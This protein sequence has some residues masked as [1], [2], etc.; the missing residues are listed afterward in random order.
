MRK[1]WKPIYLLPLALVALSVSLGGAF[2]G[3]P[4]GPVAT[5]IA[6]GQLNGPMQATFLDRSSGLGATVDANRIMVIKYDLAPGG[7]FPW[8]QHPGTVWA[9]VTKGTLTLYDAN[10]EAYPYSAGSAFFD[11]GNRTHT[12][13][14]ETGE[15]VEVIA[16]FM[17]PINAAGPSVP[18]PAPEQC[19]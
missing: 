17:L 8:H 12:A 19:S 10:C 1:Y 11:P 13:R 15:P 6:G 5:P 2:A 4:P 16:T 3:Q 14:N 9:V 18:V 7:A